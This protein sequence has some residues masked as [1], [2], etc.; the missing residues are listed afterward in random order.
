MKSNRFL[1]ISLCKW[2]LEIEDI[3]F[4]SNDLNV[5]KAKYNLVHKY[6]KYINKRSPFKTSHR[7]SN[8]NVLKKLIKELHNPNA[9]FF[10]LTDPYVIAILDTTT[11]LYYSSTRFH[12]LVGGLIPNEIT[13]IYLIEKEIVK[14]ILE[15]EWQDIFN[16]YSFTFFKLG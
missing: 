3:L 12:K 14:G 15:S 16:H 5:I 10:D 9:T 6:L 11:G 7:L 1:L 4:S 13:E 2:T 8:N